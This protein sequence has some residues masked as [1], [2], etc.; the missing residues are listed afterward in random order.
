MLSATSARMVDLTPGCWRRRDPR[1]CWK[2]SGRAAVLAGPGRA[3]LRRALVAGH[4]RV[5]RPRACPGPLEPRTCRT[6]SRR[7]RCCSSPT[8]TG[9]SA[10]RTSAWRDWP[11][12]A[13][14]T[15]AGALTETCGGTRTRWHWPPRRT[16]AALAAAAEPLLSD[17]S[18]RAGQARGRLL[19]LEFS[20]AHTLRALRRAAPPRRTHEPMRDAAP[21]A[22][23]HSR[24]PARRGLAEHGPV[25]GDA[26]EAEQSTG[27]S[28]SDAVAPPL[29]DDCRCG[30]CRVL[31]A[32]GAAFNA[33]RML[34]RF[35]L[36][37]LEALRLRSRAR[38]P[39]TWRTTATRSSCTRCPPI[40]R[41][42][43]A[44]TWTRSAAW[45]SPSRSRGR[46]GSGAMARRAAQ[47]D[48]AS[49]G[50]IPQH[51]GGARGTA[52]PRLWARERLVHAP[53]GTR[54][55][56]AR[57]PYPATT[58]EVRAPRG[59]ALPAARGQLRR[60]SG[61]TCSS[62]SSRRCAATHPELRLVQQG[63]ALTPAQRSRWRAR[64]RGR[65]AAAAEVDRA[66]LAGLYRQA[67]VVLVTSEAEGFGLP[68]IEALAC[69]PRWWPATSPCCARWAETPSPTARGRRGR[70]DG[71]GAPRA[72]VHGVRRGPEPACGARKRLLV[73]EPRAHHP[74]HLP[75]AHGV[76]KPLSL[77]LESAPGQAHL[78][79]T[80]RQ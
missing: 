62:R 42:S 65:A 77:D 25:R 49:G 69:G 35:G 31:G 21:R 36:Y 17:T 54:P 66:T 41:A 45:W 47:G 16:G 76:L 61:W 2:D 46:H 58:S 38:T 24:G 7:A 12:R 33:D 75:S 8:R 72:G 44:T 53:L 50:G 15:N 64:H 18:A 20:L 48:A 71:S 59:P 32:R 10:R 52:A 73:D 4:P 19:R 79:F 3:R 14:V 37:P 23:V 29:P 40:E 57:G 60:A 13:V 28:R 67:R 9:V 55:S 6:T 78:P 34:T 70:L 22:A 26:S 27:P 11:G 39:S 51:A 63:G 1:C 43:T 56:T 74:R 68:V 5:R 80:P 30:G